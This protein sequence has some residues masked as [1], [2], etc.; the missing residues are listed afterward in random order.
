MISVQL[1][2][3]KNEINLIMKNTSIKYDKKELDNLFDRFYRG[4][5][6]KEKGFGIGLYVVKV[7]AEKHKGSVEA[8]MEGDNIIVFNVKLK[9]F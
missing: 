6:V 1:K 4:S 8:H 3:K 2:S 5:S 9:K 7:I